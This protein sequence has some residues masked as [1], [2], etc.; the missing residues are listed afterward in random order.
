MTDKLEIKVTTQGTGKV[1]ELK[2]DW[3]LDT[4]DNRRISLS[5]LVNR[6]LQ[7]FT[8]MEVEVELTISIKEK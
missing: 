6:Q 2:E 8:G 4:N 7:K 5:G 3:V 1:A